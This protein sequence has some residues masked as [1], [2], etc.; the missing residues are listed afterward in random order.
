MAFCDFIKGID[1]FGKVPEF[2]INGKPKQAT[3]MGR[4][5]T[6]IFI[7]IYIV[8]FIYKLYRMVN[9]VDIT[10]YDSFSNTDDM[11]GI[12][13]TNDNF[14]LFL[15]VY[16]DNGLPFIDDTI[17]YPVA[18]FY[19]ENI[20]MMME[21]ERC[22]KD[23]INPNFENFFEENSQIDNYFCLNNIN[24]ILKPYENYVLL[25]IFPC[26]NTTENNNQCKSKE[27]IEEFLNFRS[28]YIF[29][30]DILITS[31]DYDFP[32][33]ERVNF[34]EGG[35]YKNI[36]QYFY[37]E[38]QLVQIETNTN[39]IGFDF[40]T[41]PK[42]DE[43]IKFDNVEIIPEPGYDLNDET[44]DLP[45]VEIAFQLNDRIL[46]EKRQYMQFIDVLG[47]VGGLMEFINSF[48]GMI[49]SFVVD[50]LYEKEII[51][52]LFS[53]D[54]KKKY[55]YI[56]KDKKS[57]YKINNEIFKEEKNKIKQNIYSFS[58]NANINKE[59][60]I[61]IKTNGE[62]ISDKRSENYL[63]NKK[64]I[65]K[66]NNSLK[67]ENNINN[68]EKFSVNIR[69]L[70]NNKAESF[71]S[72]TKRLEKD[73][74]IKNNERWIIDKINLNDLLKSICF[75]KRQ[76]KNVYKIILD[77]TM[78]I[79]I[80]KLDIFN[81]FRAIFKIETIDGN[82]NKLG[83]IQRSQEYSNIFSEIKK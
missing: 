13:I 33:K 20:E 37:T 51:N 2:Y 77:E 52:N 12:K 22:S 44:N 48:F 63:I 49:C 21:I 73:S 62:D 54:I 43:Y 16:D 29:F 41:N 58:I 69:N 28:V 76:N 75:C 23:K 39:I 6:V 71:L 18:Y 14:S 53:F 1:F 15:T 35:I 24:H 47:E 74:I 11:L 72:L 57:L 27:F 7:I 78:E 68:Q 50:I 8:I 81:I 36:G 56:K 82:Y 31:L 59:N 83:I 45:G 4:I 55:I 25:Q 40:L 67:I 38:M 70:N 65:L 34:I 3:F 46:L 42:M 17:Y 80:D 19:G 5:F 26:Q 64:C 60:F 30:G 66:D 32:V 79:I 10:F 61:K 9:R